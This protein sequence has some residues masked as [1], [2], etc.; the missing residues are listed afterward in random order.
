MVV[1]SN[2]SVRFALKSIPADAID[3]G[4]AMLRFIDNIFF[5]WFVL[6]H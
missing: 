1:S 4:G 3:I 6:L 2:N 5:I